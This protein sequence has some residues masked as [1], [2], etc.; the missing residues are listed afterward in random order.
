MSGNHKKEKA[1]RR[2]SG[3]P[4]LLLT[5]SALMAQKCRQK[6][7]M[8]TLFDQDNFYNHPEYLP[9]S[10]QY[11]LLAKK[12][13]I[14]E[15][16]P[17]MSPFPWNNGCNGIASMRDVSKI[18]RDFNGIKST[19]SM[20]MS[21]LWRAIQLSLHHFFITSLLKKYLTV[22]VNNCKYEKQLISRSPFTKKRGKFDGCKIRRCSNHRRTGYLP[23]DIQIDSLQVSS[24]RSNSFTESRETLAVQKRRNWP[25]ARRKEVVRFKE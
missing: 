3:L 6:S 12:N 22:T 7:N 11:S 9:H 23:Q 13:I 4:S 16:D 15:C 8:P 10:C 1:A 17:G 2:G 20:M 19:L 5:W 14:F 18:G 24:R 25:L 21:W